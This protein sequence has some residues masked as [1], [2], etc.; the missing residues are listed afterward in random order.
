MHAVILRYMVTP[1]SL[2]DQSTVFILRPDAFCLFGQ[3]D[4]VN[5]LECLRAGHIASHCFLWGAR[6]FLGCREQSWR[7]AACHY[8]VYC[9]M[10][11]VKIAFVAFLGGGQRTN[12][13]GSC[14]H[15]KAPMATCLL[16]ARVLKFLKCHSF[17]FV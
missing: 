7:T 3:T 11:A 5:T 14:L 8:C 6:K 10:I 9:K 2:Q 1:K 12:L 17:I 15:P 13:G 4:S 16:R